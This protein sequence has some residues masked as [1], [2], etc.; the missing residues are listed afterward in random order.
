MSRFIAV[1]V[2]SALAGACGAVEGKDVTVTI[3][4]ESPTTADDLV[5]TI[6]GG[7]GLAFRWSV[8]GGVRTDQT[9]N[10]IGAS[11]TT[12]HEVWTVEAVE[13]GRAL[14]S[15]EV[16]IANS[17]PTLPR[18]TAPASP[19]AAAPIQ[20]LVE[21][22][23]TDADGDP[24][25]T[26]LTWTLDGAPFAGATTTVVPNDTIPQVTTHTGNVFACT[27]TATEPE[28]SVR[29]TATSTVAPRTAY[30][31]KQDVTPQVLQ[32][33]D[34]DRGTITDVGPL[35]VTM[36]Y[37]DLAW[38]RVN[39]KLYM[40]DGRGA[41][42]LYTVDTATGAATLIGTHGLVDAFGLAFHPGDNNRLYLTTTGSGNTLYRMNVTTGA[43]TMVAAVGSQGR[44]EGMAFDSRRNQFVGMTVSG[45]VLA[46]NAITGAAAQ[47]GT[48][49]GMNDFG[50][51]YDP[52]IDRFW[53]VD[54]SARLISIDPTAAYA[55]TIVAQSIL[56]HAAIAIALPPP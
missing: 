44:M 1:L 43:P 39:Q 2:C 49:G 27:F 48:T 6:E 37:G 45:Q 20:C 52:F 4:P 46:I 31:I 41:Q 15:A 38:D 18:V 34:L 51:T 30:M 14:A 40:I 11:L 36:Q 19:I 5:A 50:L 10:R 24:V 29:A 33:I 3:S 47:I 54:V 16:T 26:S 21:G 25:Q 7:T 56:S 53:A 9:T 13:N 17:P 23:S 22:T 35:D 28:G 32:T 8:N 55:A 12:K 42:A